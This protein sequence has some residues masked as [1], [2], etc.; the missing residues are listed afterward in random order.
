MEYNRL[1]IKHAWFSFLIRMKPLTVYWNHIRV[2][3]IF[4]YK[5]KSK[6]ERALCLYLDQK[7]FNS[8]TIEYMVLLRAA[9]QNQ[10]YLS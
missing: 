2:I 1:L 5:I 4:L 6:E 7:I 8:I 3:Q 9:Y 10:S